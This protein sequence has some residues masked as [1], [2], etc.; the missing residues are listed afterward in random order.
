[1]S[2]I[3]IYAFWLPVCGIILIAYSDNI[4]RLAKKLKKLRFEAGTS[5]TKSV[6][7]PKAVCYAGQVSAAEAIVYWPGSP[8]LCLLHLLG[9]SYGKINVI[10]TQCIA[11]DIAT[12]GG[13]LAIAWP[14]PV[15]VI[16]L[17]NAMIP[18][19]IVVWWSHHPG[20][21]MALVLRNANPTRKFVSGNTQIVHFSSQFAAIEGALTSDHHHQQHKDSEPLC[22]TNRFCH[23]ERINWNR[24]SKWIIM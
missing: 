23:L 6:I 16:D 9:T 8:A 3:Y 7:T 17:K 13:S 4:I 20:S 22:Q 18:G 14:A 15:A 12:V 11:V 21:E 10:C 19:S 5:S 24:K 2:N 1:M